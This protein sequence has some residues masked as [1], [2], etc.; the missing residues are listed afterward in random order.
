MPPKKD[1]KPKRKVRKVKKVIK[2]KIEPGSYGSLVKSIEGLRG[3]LMRSNIPMPGAMNF[4]PFLADQQVSQI[5]AQASNTVAKAVSEANMRLRDAQER[6]LSTFSEMPVS[7]E[8]AREYEEAERYAPSVLAEQKRRGRPPGTK[9]K[10]KKPI[11]PLF[12]EQEEAEKFLS[13]KPGTTE[14]VY[15]TPYQALEAMEKQ[16]KEQRKAKKEPIFLET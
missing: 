13:I 16:R 5:R 6:A 2:P 3:S 4:T 15:E 11:E 1:K 9:N 10:P 14:F 12:E 8:K 7:D